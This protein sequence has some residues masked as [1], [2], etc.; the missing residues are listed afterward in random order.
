MKCKVVAMTAEKAV[1]DDVY[2]RKTAAV[3]KTCST[4]LQQIGSQFILLS[5]AAKQH[6]D[7]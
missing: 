1:K 2:H 7:L 4:T 6:Y 3:C 5:H